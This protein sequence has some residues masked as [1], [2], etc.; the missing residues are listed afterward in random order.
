MDDL[1]KQYRMKTGIKSAHRD[2]CWDRRNRVEMTPYCN[3]R[4]YR[5]EHR[6]CQ[7][8]IKGTNNDATTDDDVVLSFERNHG[9]V[10]ESLQTFRPLRIRIHPENARRTMPWLCIHRSHSRYL[11]TDGLKRGILPKVIMLKGLFQS[12]RIQSVDRT[13]TAAICS[14]Q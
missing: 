8:H 4:R 11:V 2:E 9:Q 14:S 6:R 3:T 13:A 7:L 1:S 10:I 12:R 5:G